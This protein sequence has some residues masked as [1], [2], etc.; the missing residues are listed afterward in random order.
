MPVQVRE[1]CS[2]NVTHPGVDREFR[3]DK[4]VM[5]KLEMKFSLIAIDHGHEQN[6]A[7]MKEE[8]GL[9]GL[10]QDPGA[11]LR[12]SVAGP[13]LVRVISE[14]ESATRRNTRYS[15]S[16]HHEQ[17]KAN[18][19]HMAAKVKSLVGVMTD[20]GNQF[21]EESP[22]LLRPHSRGIMDKASVECLT[23]IKCRGED[24]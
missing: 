13:E 11:L 2:L 18:Q 6:N 1:M 8:G 5:A 7:I 21:E 16:R 9:I 17:S 10:T 20:M 4:Y 19:K 12:W 23:T 3:N 14:F 15:S 22:Y 24:Q